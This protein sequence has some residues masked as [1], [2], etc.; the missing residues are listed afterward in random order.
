MARAEIGYIIT[1]DNGDAA[2]AASVQVNVRATGNPAT[3]YSAE[4]G[5][6]TTANPIAVT[7]G[8]IEGWLDEGSYNFII[9]GT[10]ITS[11]TQPVEIVRGD[12]VGN[13]ADNAVT[14]SK[15]ANGTIDLGAKGAAGSL[16]LEELGADII[17]QL[18][19]IGAVIDWY[20][21]ASSV[22][23]PTGF[24]ICDG[25]TTLTTAQHDFGHGS[26][27]TVPDLRHKFIVGARA[28]SDGTAGT[29]G[30]NLGTQAPGIRGE[31]GTNALRDISHSHSVASHYHYLGTLAVSTNGSHSHTSS[32]GSAGSHNHGGNTGGPTSLSHTHNAGARLFLITGDVSDSGFASGTSYR[33]A[34]TGTVSYTDPYHTHSIVS[35]GTHAHTISSDGNHSH[36]VSGYVGNGSGSNGDNGFNTGTAGTTALAVLPQYYGLLK[37]MKVKRS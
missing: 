9:T 4:T 6:A 1:K 34:T 7:N 10:G 29:A 31:G 18:L 16:T 13:I 27:F 32:T 20:R 3:V 19:P 30:S 35:D 25:A 17:R 22:A 33:F 21:P 23:V 15:I 36:G 24:V 11:Y 14:N 12:G 8:R 5:G 28:D 37:I 2:T 26:S